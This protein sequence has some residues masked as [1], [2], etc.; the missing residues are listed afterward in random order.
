MRDLR[1]LGTS[2]L[3]AALMLVSIAPTV[4]E[5][6]V[7]RPVR[8]QAHSLHAADQQGA[9]RQQQRHQPRGD[10]HLGGGRGVRERGPPARPQD[11]HHPQGAAGLLH[12]RQLHRPGRRT[13][14]RPSN[15]ARV[16]RNGPK[17]SYVADNQSGGCG[18]DN[19][20][21]YKIQSFNVSL[22]GRQGRL[23]R[24]E[25]QERRLHAF[26]EQRPDAAVRP[27]A[28]ARWCA[29]DSG[30]RRERHA[31]PVPVLSDWTCRAVASGVPTPPGQRVDP[32]QTTRID[33]FPAM[34]TGSG[35]AT[36]HLDGRR[37][38]IPGPC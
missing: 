3:L 14:T 18:G 20:D 31:H 13:P 21:N 4:R 27:A 6:G 11:R 9:L 36:I 5:R 16:V 17:L 1:L 2:G 35:G 23:H 30:W 10:L 8:C 22:H 32:G 29:A 28:Q 12:R 7:P 24:R 25:G 26:V 38:I 37:A 19:G 33:R 34:V 15:K